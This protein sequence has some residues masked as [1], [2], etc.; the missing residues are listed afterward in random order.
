MIEQMLLPLD[1]ENAFIS[2]LLNVSDIKAEEDSDIDKLKNFN[3]DVQIY[4][5]FKRKYEEFIIIRI[6]LNIVRNDGEEYLYNED[7]LY[8][9]FNNIEHNDIVWMNC[10]YN[11]YI[12]YLR[13][14]VINNFFFKAMF[15]FIKKVY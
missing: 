6:N 9:K 7:D 2:I 13:F 8:L 1:L 12:L 5:A 4:L 11:Y 3:V 15:R 14:K 10:I